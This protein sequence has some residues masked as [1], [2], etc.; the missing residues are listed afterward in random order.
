MP[1][2]SIVILT[3][4]GKQTIKETLDSVLAQD[5]F[6]RSAKQGSAKEGSYDNLEIIIVDNASTDGTINEIQNGTSSS[7][8]TAKFKIIINKKN[9]GFSGGHN[10]GIRAS[11][12][13]Y[14]LCMNQDVI[15]EPNFISEAV[16]LFQQ[17][18]KIGAIQP[19]MLNGRD[20]KIIDST[21]I[22][23]FKSRRMVDRGQGEEDK[24]QY[25]KIEEVFGANGAA[26]FFRKK[27]LEDVA[28]RELFS[29]Y[30]NSSRSE[31]WDED[32]FIY[33]EDVDLSWRIRLY[34]WKIMY[35]PTAVVYTDRTTKPISEKAGAGEM[36]KTRKKQKQY[37]RHYSFKNHYLAIIKNDLPGLFFKHLPWILPREIGAWLYVL[38]FEPK[39]WPAIGELFKQMPREWKKR[40]IIM[41]NRRVGSKEMGKWFQ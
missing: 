22:I 34:G 10:V 14:I 3:F 18:E 12:G 19:K 40:K 28:L 9:L 11:R 8:A 26:A 16:K 30:E 20:R 2:A 27:C 35:C 36:I 39:T 6:A 13:E 33:K 7:Q 4:N 32:F 24:G 41:K 15:L 17:D 31:Y 21:G 23:M 5:Y 1:L 38:F 29:Y 25:E 37:V